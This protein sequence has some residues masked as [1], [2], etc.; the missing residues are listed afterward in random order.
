[1]SEFV[2]AHL[3]NWAAWASIAGL[4]A[5][6]W[7]AIAAT[8]AKRAAERARRE[9]RQKVLLHSLS[10]ARRDLDQLDDAVLRRDFS[11]A[12]HVARALAD[13]VEELANTLASVGQKRKWW[14]P[15]A[16]RASRKTLGRATGEPTIDRKW[17]TF[18]T[19]LREWRATF[20]GIRSQGG[21]KRLENVD[22]WCRFTQRMKH[23]INT[24]IGPV[25]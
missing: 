23:E 19:E 13:Y 5:S 22:E 16:K 6:L 15:F 9:I 24:F 17:G 25:T 21:H 10:T 20:V 8:N 3:Q 12:V 4:A 2:V 7:A 1:M 11:L 18:A 14:M